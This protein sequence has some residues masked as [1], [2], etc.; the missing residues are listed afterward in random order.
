MRLIFADGG[1]ITTYNKTFENNIKN[2]KIDNAKNMLQHN[3]ILGVFY[4]VF[5]I[6]IRKLLLTPSIKNRLILPF[7][8]VH[9]E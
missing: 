5:Q 8:D 6:L 3:S 7:W 2:R 1:S 4:Y 9:K